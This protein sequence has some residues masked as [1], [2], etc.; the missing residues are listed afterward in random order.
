MPRARQRNVE[1]AGRSI[2]GE[3][4]PL[5]DPAALD[6]DPVLPEATHHGRLQLA[7]AK[8]PEQEDDQPHQRDQAQA[9]QQ[10]PARVPLLGAIVVRRARAG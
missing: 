4:L 3:A 5:D 10:R 9:D 8:R 7:L 2:L 1:R 6:H